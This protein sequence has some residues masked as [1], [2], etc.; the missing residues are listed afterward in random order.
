MS[1]PPAA[2]RRAAEATAKLPLI[3]GEDVWAQR[4]EAAFALAPHLHEIG[5]TQLLQVMR[6]RGRRDLELLDQA[7]AGHVRL[8]RD[9]LEDREPGRI[10]ERLG[11]A[12]EASIVH[13]VTISVLR[14]AGQ[15]AAR[16]WAYFRLRHRRL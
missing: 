12:H 15:R 6:H 8:G 13:T 2:F 16:P 9:P 3:G 7:L 11:D 5:A 4:E 1:R 10:G 14:R